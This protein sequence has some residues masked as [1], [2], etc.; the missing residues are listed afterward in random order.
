VEIAPNI[1]LADAVC[2]IVSSGSTLF[3]N[4]LKEAQVIMQSEAVLATS[5]KIAEEQ[6][7]ILTKLLFRIQAVLKGKSTKYILLNV[8]N[9]KIQAVSDILPVLKSPTV[10]PLV[11]EGWSSLHS[12]IQ[13][14]EFW[15]VLDQL[16]EAGAEDILV[17]PID[18]MIA[19]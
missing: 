13:E 7:R 15:D 11:Q 4:G 10:L 8:P 19:V 9:E 16:K 18:K 2:D 5:P 14:D 6:Q 3:K 1:G 12:V 17:V